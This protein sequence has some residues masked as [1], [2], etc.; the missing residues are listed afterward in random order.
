MGLRFYK[1]IQILPFLR[2]NISKSGVSF[3][4]GRPGA[5]INIGPQGTRGSV[6]LPGTGLSYR[7]KLGGFGSGMRIVLIGLGVIAALLAAFFK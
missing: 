6:G 1:S 3:S 5:S 2:L 4:L 7:K